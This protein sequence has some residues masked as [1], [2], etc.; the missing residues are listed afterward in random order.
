MLH[1]TSP[2]GREALLAREGHP[3]AIQVDLQHLDFHH[4]AHR[5]HLARVLH[6]LVGKLRDVDQSVLMDTDVHKRPE[7]GHVRHHPFQDHPFAQIVRVWPR[8]AP[9]SSAMARRRLAKWQR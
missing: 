6:I 4:V 2:A 1:N 3:A 9:A 5:D 7:T 8:L